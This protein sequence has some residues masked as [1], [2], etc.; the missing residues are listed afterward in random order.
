MLTDSFILVIDQHGLDS[1]KV[2][3]FIRDNLS[4]KDFIESALTTIRIRNGE[5]L[6]ELS[7]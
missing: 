3:Q 5:L 4:N 2:D 1:G 6:R 7:T